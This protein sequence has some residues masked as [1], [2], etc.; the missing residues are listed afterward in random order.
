MT[1]KAHSF[2]V[3]LLKNGY[4]ASNSLDPGHKL[5]E[6]HLA[7][8]IP[9]VKRVFILKGQAKPPWWKAYFH[10]KDDL[11]QIFQGSLVFLEA[12]NRYFAVSFGNSYNHLKDESYEYDFGLRVT[13]NCIDPDKIRNTDSVSADSARRQRTQM[14]SDSDLTF[15]DVDGDA[16]ILKA[17]TGKVRDDYKEK[18][19]SA[20]GTNSLRMSTRAD[21]NSLAALLGEL[22]GLYESTEYQTRFPSIRNIQPVKDPIVIT[23]L[24]DSL[25]EA[26]KGQSASVMMAIPDLVEYRDGLFSDFSGAG[27]SQV[28]DDVSIGAYYEYL[29]DNSFDF[30]TLVFA[31]L[32]K[33]KT[34]L[35]NSDN[36][37][38]R[39]FS[40]HRCFVFETTLTGDSAAYHCLDGSWYRVEKEFLEELTTYLDARITDIDLR[41][42][43]EHLEGDY[44]EETGKLDGYVCLDRTDISPTGATNIE[45][46]DLITLKDGR[47]LLIHVK[48]GTSARELSHLFN[49]GTNSSELLKSNPQARQNLEEIVE[50]RGKVGDQ[51]AEIVTSIRA[52]R[53]SVMY[54]IITHKDAAERSVNLPLFSKISLRRSLRT[55]DSMDVP[56]LCGFVKDEAN[57]SGK[58]KTRKPRKKKRKST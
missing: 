14:P 31:T 55:L 25:V 18:I 54:A 22:V 43:I 49:Q 19:G 1:Q 10:L 15:F 11:P 21:A 40:A 53:Y 13:L 3:Y 58:V 47:A 48:I 41:D 27:P 2:S 37:V 38:K 30:A 35:I 42:C 20:T 7:I 50:D 9:G 34:R 33:H 29:N 57:R 26:I 52:R 28:Y 44:N 17:L 6:S 45:P 32:Q 5:E 8:S 16:T 39:S 23:G 12:E 56:V 51:I 36:D 4:D 46:C 24:N